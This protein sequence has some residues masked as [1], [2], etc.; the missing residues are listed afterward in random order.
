MNVNGTPNLKCWSTWKQSNWGQVRDQPASGKSLVNLFTFTCEI[1][2]IVMRKLLD[3]AVP[4]L[5]G[6]LTVVAHPGQL[7]SKGM[8]ETLCRA[9]SP[10]D[11]IASLGNAFCLLSD[12][13]QL[14]YSISL[15]GPH[16]RL[17]NERKH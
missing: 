13:R 15:I 16:F 8:N 17:E 1:K 3:K 10:R 14:V 2:T 6:A 5:V 12:V 9:R 7:I 11:L 4:Y